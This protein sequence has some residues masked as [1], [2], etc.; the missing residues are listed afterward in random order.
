[1]LSSRLAVKRENFSIDNQRQICSHVKANSLTKSARWATL[2][3]SRRRPFLC[4][5]YRDENG[6]EEKS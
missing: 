6:G 4:R 2:L 1:M 3:H 5:L